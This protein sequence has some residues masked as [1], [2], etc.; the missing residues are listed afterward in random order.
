MYGRDVADVLGSEISNGNSGHKTASI[1]GIA[2]VAWKSSSYVT[3]SRKS[4]TTKDSKVHKGN[5]ILVRFPLWTFVSFVVNSDFRKSR[6]RPSLRP[7]TWS[8]SHSVPCGA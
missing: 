1:S 7:R 8:P 4:L 6:Q 3:T 2:S 5:P